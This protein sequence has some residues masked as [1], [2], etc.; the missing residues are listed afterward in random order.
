MHPVHATYTWWKNLKYGSVYLIVLGRVEEIIAGT[1]FFMLLNSC[2]PRYIFNNDV[3]VLEF[4]AQNFLLPHL[5][6]DFPQG[7]FC[8][9]Y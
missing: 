9:V 6:K 2:R 3:N 5:I 8:V 1:S 7:I 4:C